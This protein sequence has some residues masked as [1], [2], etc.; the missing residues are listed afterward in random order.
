MRP[1]VGVAA[2]F[3]NTSRE[4]IPSQ[5]SFK[6]SDFSKYFL[7]SYIASAGLDRWLR[8]YIVEATHVI[9][10]SSPPEKHL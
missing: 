6:F 5:Y 4:S 3:L 2:P 9:N 1:V 8:L 7:F 10:C